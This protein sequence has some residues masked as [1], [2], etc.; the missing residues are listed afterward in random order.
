MLTDFI[1][2]FH[3]FSK[4][5]ENQILLEAN[6]LILI[7]HKPFLGSRDITQKKLG[8]ISSAVL[9]FIG[10]KQTNRQTS[11]IYI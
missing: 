3:V 4:L 5:K 6:L 1:K 7:I 11:K 2:Q 8:P 9:A 10:Y